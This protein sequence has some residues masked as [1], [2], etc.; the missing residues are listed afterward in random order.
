M[1]EPVVLVVGAGLAGFSAAAEIAGA[2]LRVLVVEQ[3]AAPG[4]A[5]HRQPLPGIAYPV[6][7]AVHRRRWTQVTASV[8]AQGDR[9]EIRYGCRFAGLDHEGTALLTGARNALVRPRAL[10]IATGAA[11]RVRPR[12]GWTL[13]NVM[14]AGALQI[15]T[16]TLGK[17]P[18]GRI[19]LGGSGP[20]LLAAGA[21]LVK[22][23]NPPVA[24]IEAG[25]PFRHVIG[26]LGLPLP[27][28][29]EAAGYMATLLRARVPV[30]TGTEIVRI[31]KRSGALTLHVESSSGGRTFDGD[32]I[33]LHDGIRASDHY[34]A[35]SSIPVMRAGDCREAL[36]ARAALADGRAA[37]AALVAELTGTVP[38]SAKDSSRIERE[39]RAQRRLA[40]IFGHDGSARLAALPADTVICR[41]E[42]RTVG[43]LRALGPVPTDR[44][45]RLHGRFAM[46]ACQGRFCT[47]WVRALTDP[48]HAGSPLGAVRLPA[49]PI[50]I[51]DLLDAGGI[52][53]NPSTGE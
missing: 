26:S 31:E 1:N 4:G 36:G 8:R 35:A 30:L 21:E 28:L 7:S 11:E 3:A 20:L 12:P 51:A 22:G 44:D 29:R 49:H 43:D 39:R 19:L 13:P 24:I 2:G 18:D 34:A 48:S 45:L 52:A 42:N 25:R 50:A 33:G 27:Y 40:R 17:A 16:K 38:A 46:G 37:G 23:G 6:A 10:V 41:C 47:E 15:R 5:I 53:D 14:T 32:L 9:I